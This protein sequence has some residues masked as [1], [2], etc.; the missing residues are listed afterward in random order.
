MERL[1]KG[2]SG[3]QLYVVS[4][5][6][7]SDNVSLRFILK[8]N[9][10]QK[11]VFFY[12]DLAS[13]VP[14]DVPRVLDARILD[15]GRAWLLMEE[16]ADVKDPLT[17]DEA[18]YK[19][20]L[21]DMARLHAQFWGQ[22]HLLDD[23]T[24]LW[25]PDERSLQELAAARKSDLE[26]IT[27]SW[28][29]QALPEV[30]GT[31]RLSLAKLVLEQPDSVFG[32]LLAAGTTLVHGDYWFHNVQITGTGR[33]SLVDWQD[34]QVW[35]G[36]W[37]LVYFLN[38][39]LAVGPGHFR[40]ELPFDEG[41]MVG[42]YADA[43][44]EAGVDVPRG[45][46]DQALLAACVWH[47]LQHWVRQ[48]GYAITRDLLPTRDLRDAYPGAVRFLVSTFSRWERDARTLLGV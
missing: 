31:D 36:L 5:D 9:G 48:Y 17:W 13:R 44:A 3:S 21:S 45:A 2:T 23:C 33:R 24:W 1:N 26:V 38:L 32:P 12:R 19:A 25:R 8:V 28:L 40:E 41:L 14:V 16:I 42:W 4:V 30:F 27:G 46:F 11:E 47:P 10:G 20:V 34:P 29:P 37:E 6:R 39:L 43:L 22:T 18:D 15:D 7:T 35:S